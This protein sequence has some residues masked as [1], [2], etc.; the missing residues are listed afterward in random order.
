ML[1]VSL[2]KMRD[3]PLVRDLPRVR[4]LDLSLSA[5]DPGKLN[6]QLRKN[7]RTLD[8]RDSETEIAGLDSIMAI[9][10]ASIDSLQE[11]QLLP[12][13]RYLVIDRSRDPAFQHEIHPLRFDA[14]DLPLLRMPQTMSGLYLYDGH[15]T[16]AA[17]SRAMI[18]IH[19]EMIGD[20]MRIY[21]LAEAP[22]GGMSQCKGP[23]QQTDD[24][25]SHPRDLTKAQR[26]ALEKQKLLSQLTKSR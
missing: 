17:S 16:H 11:H 19:L 24:L 1:G 23:I 2:P 14:Q 18:N 22:A 15:P 4:D 13:S 5:K 20:L 6:A 21:Y 9:L 10:S 7:A 8:S 25:I 3:L 26:Q 12:L